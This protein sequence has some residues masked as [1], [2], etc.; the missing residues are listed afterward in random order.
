MGRYALIFHSGGLGDF[1]LSW[2][3]GLALGRLHPQSR[4]IYV[5]PSSKG[6]LVSAALGLEWRD[7]ETGW[8]G[9][10]SNPSGM[11]DKTLKMVA[12]AHSVFTFI[13]EAGDQFCKNVAMLA[14]KAAIVPLRT[15]PPAGYE[16]HV[17]AFLLE[18]L[19]G[20]P[21]VRGAVEQ[22]IASINK[23]G[24]A[25]KLA[26]MG[27]IVIHPGSGGREKC[28][29]I[30]GWVNLIEKMG[31]PV[32]LVLGEVE[33]E[34]WA[35]ADIRR[36]ESVA[37]VIRPATYSDLYAVLI[38]SSGFIGL[39]SGPGHLA[40]MLGLPTLT[41]FGPSEPVI[42]RPMGPK[43]AVIRHLPL[44]ELFADDVMQVVKSLF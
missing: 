27:P 37:R 18:Q 14:P 30:D 42:W 16:K 13:A 40:A 35:E 22:I 6:E 19:A 15:A 44:A 2:P 4:I 41:L 24:L 5:T 20:L 26:R 12:E 38:G 1:V 3:L 25:G 9:L 11:G 8:S 17:S 28:W 32:S 10:Y 21:A 43:T 39:D 7:A 23:N 29:T 33:I 34:R 31:R 36:L